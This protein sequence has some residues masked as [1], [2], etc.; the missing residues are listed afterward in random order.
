MCRT[1]MTML[2]TLTNYHTTQ[3]FLKTALKV[4]Y[5]FAFINNMFMNFLKHILKVSFV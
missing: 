3:V 4:S 5:Y 1:K 2:Q